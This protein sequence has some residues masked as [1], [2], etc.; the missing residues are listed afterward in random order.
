MQSY[1]LFIHL[2]K[3]TKILVG[4]LGM[5]NFLKGTYVYTGS[6]KRNL[7]SRLR[8][9]FTKEKKLHWHID[10]F[11]NY[12]NIEI[13]KVIKSKLDECNL[14]QRLNGKILAKGFGS[15]DCRKFCKSHLKYIH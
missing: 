15:S 4:K 14:N 9:H 10:Y 8:R 12:K 7:D 6:A 13:I 3:D 11:L 1:Q 5:F 2:S